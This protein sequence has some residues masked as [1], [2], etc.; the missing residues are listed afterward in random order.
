MVLSPFFFIC[1]FR[2]LYICQCTTLMT[3]IF[4][5]LL[6]KI[7]TILYFKNIRRDKLNI[8][9]TNIYFYTLVGNYDQSRLYD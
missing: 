2:F 3:N 5:Y 9:Y 8:L 7:M 6:Q 1:R 4:I